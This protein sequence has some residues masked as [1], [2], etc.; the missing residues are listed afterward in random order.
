M[1]KRELLKAIAAT[2]TISLL[3]PLTQ[4]ADME[5]VRIGAVS[6]LSGVFEQQ[7]Q[8]VLRA[9]EFAVEEANANGGVDGRK[10]EL[11][12]ADDEST[13]DG[14]RRS[15]EKL[16][17]EGHNLL[18]G[19]ISSS[20]SMTLSQNLDRWDAMYVVVASK[21]DA[22]TG[23]SCH[24][25]MFRTNHNDVMDLAMMKEWMKTVKEKKFGIIA[26]DYTWGHSSA[27]FFEKTAAELGKE[28]KVSLFAPLGTKDF[29]PYVAQLRDAD[30]EAV[31]VAMVG[32][33]AISFVKQ[34]DSFGLNDSKRLV[35]HALIF[36]YLIDA[37][38]DA[39]QNV[40]GNIGYGADIDTAR[41]RKFVAAWMDKFGRVPTEN[42]G[43]AYN[44]IQA[45]FEG[46]H[47]AGSTEPGAVSKALENASY[48]TI[49]GQAVMRGADHQLQIPDYIGQVT[50]VDG[51]LRPV[52]ER[53]YPVDLYAE[54]SPECAL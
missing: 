38:G 24:A 3:S 18:I 21:M 45:I 8:E 23:K 49:Y 10:V 13:P 32:R 51:K 15:A 27:E 36:Q 35:G 50:K 12:I 20:I 25:R 37:T 33:D 28:V 6:S 5:P 54:P 9:I 16:A 40:W 14:A 22:L 52:I 46:V 30:I 44:G 19:P 17:R 31:W 34:A 53:S 48:E 41:N 1:K 2:A 4:A 29:A 7:G 42:E 47:L 26:A 11:E 39:T 43:Q